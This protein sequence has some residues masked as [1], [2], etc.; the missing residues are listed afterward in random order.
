M[1]SRIMNKISKNVN[2]TYKDHTKIEHL[3]LGIGMG[4]FSAFCGFSCIYDSMNDKIEVSEEARKTRNMGLG[5]TAI[6]FLVSSYHITRYLK[7]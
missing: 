4:V 5:L 1:M 7:K 3:D 6:S 2:F